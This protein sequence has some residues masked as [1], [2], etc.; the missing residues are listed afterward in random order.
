L[1]KGDVADHMVLACQARPTSP[2]VLIDA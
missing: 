2:E 1:L